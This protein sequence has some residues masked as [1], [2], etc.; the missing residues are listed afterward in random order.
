MFLG[1]V[2]GGQATYL[3]TSSHTA[4][5]AKARKKATIITRDMWEGID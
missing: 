1:G 5:T 3:K 2:K 4:A